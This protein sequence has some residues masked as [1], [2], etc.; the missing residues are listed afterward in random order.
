MGLEDLIDSAI[1]VRRQVPDALIVIAGKGPLA[2]TLARR[3]A[4]AGL[5]DHVRLAGFIA[6]EELPVAYRAADITVVPSVALEGFGL[7]VAESLSAGTPVLVTDV[8][9]LPETIEQLAPQCVI[10]N[11]DSESMGAAIAGAIAGKVPLPS[12]RE[13]VAYA[14][15]HFDWSHLAERV[16]AAYRETVQ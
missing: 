4:D 9:G 14:K 12:A 7:V 6:D 8:G 16:S 2:N 15:S 11:R 5:A 13:C 1:H 10:D 3:I